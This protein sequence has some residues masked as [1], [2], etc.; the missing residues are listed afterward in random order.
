MRDATVQS[1]NSRHAQRH[2]SRQRKAPTDGS[3]GG[4]SWGG[5]RIGTAQGAQGNETI[6]L[7][8]RAGIDCRFW[9]AKPSRSPLE[10]FP[11]NVVRLS[12][13]HSPLFARRGVEEAPTCNS[14]DVTKASI[15][16]GLSSPTAFDPASHAAGRRLRA[17]IGK[18]QFARRRSVAHLEQVLNL[19]V[20]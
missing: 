7:V 4:A 9:Q 16:A 2:M 1:E 3:K 17:A 12:R 10:F 13:Q 15:G 6:L 20:T 14:L 19:G 18:H 5:K 8:N 11:S